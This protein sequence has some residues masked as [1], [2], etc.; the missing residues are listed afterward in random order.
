M[1]CKCT[2]LLKHLAVYRV[3]SKSSREAVRGA[4]NIDANTDAAPTMAY[5]GGPAIDKIS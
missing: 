3:N 2:L 1:P 5:A 4:L